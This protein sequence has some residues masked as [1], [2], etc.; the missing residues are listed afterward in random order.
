MKYVAFKCLVSLHLRPGCPAGLLA[1]HV[2][3]A[4]AIDWADRYAQLAAGAV[5]VDHR[6]H[7]FVAAKNRVGW[8]HRQAQRAAN[9]PSLVNHGHT[10]RTFQAVG[11]VQAQGG[12]ARDG[13]QPG[14]AFRAARRALVDGRALLGNRLG[15]GQA[16]RVAA[17]RALRLRQCSVDAAGQAG[18]LGSVRVC[19]PAIVLLYL[20]RAA[21]TGA[22]LATVLATGLASGLATGLTS[23]NFLGAACA[24]FDWATALFAGVFRAWLAS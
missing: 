18:E 20:L 9:A 3:Q 22:R 23:A 2:L 16:V 14:N 8:A 1:G 12:L 4:D 13:S 15:V 6:V 24:R 21:L 7:H 19:H 17:A 11:G 10:T 5:R